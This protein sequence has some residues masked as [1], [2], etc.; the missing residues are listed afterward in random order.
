VDQEA[1]LGVNSA[2]LGNLKGQ[3]REDFRQLLVN[4]RKILDKLNE[5]VYNIVKEGQSV[6]IKDYDCPSWSHKQAHTNGVLEMAKK[7]AKLCEIKG[8]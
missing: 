5:I 6:D 1:R 2:W 3:D 4:N 8:A 7:I